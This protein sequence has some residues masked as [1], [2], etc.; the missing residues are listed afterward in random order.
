[1]ENTRLGQTRHSGERKFIV[2]HRKTDD[3]LPG[4]VSEL[5]ELS[6]A[7]ITDLRQLQINESE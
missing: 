2:V 5:K 6:A 3:Y 1:M 7:R 4:Q